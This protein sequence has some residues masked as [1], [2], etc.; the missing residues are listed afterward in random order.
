[1]ILNVLRFF[2][3]SRDNDKKSR[4]LCLPLNPF[5]ISTSPSFQVVLLFKVIRH[6]LPANCKNFSS[7]SFSS[8]AFDNSLC[9]IPVFSFISKE[10]IFSYLTKLL[11][12]SIF[13]K[14]SILTASIEMIASFF[15]F[16][17]VVRSLYIT[18]FP[19]NG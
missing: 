2:K 5:S 1:M 7:T 15:L 6:A 11:N 10:S 12:S 4:N 17:P 8:G 9:F 19:S 16:S 13:L 3:K 14:F 18:Y